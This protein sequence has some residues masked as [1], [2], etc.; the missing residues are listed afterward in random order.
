MTLR[1]LGV[2]ESDCDLSIRNVDLCSCDRS[3]S[4]SETAWARRISGFKGEAFARVLD[5]AAARQLQ[6]N[7]LYCS[8]TSAFSCPFCR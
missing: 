5:I 6:Y 8:L 4:N 3:A 1:G 2:V 7:K